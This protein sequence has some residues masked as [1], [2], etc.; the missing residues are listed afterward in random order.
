M[1]FWASLPEEERQRMQQDTMGLLGGKGFR[2]R[3]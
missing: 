3:F 1:E 2:C